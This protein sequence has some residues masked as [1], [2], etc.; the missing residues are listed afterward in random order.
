MPELGDLLSDDEV[1]TNIFQPTGFC[2]DHGIVNVKAVY[3]STVDE[4][5]NMKHDWSYDICQHC[6]KPV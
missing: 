1:H 4:D 2:K 5:G 6:G 3:E